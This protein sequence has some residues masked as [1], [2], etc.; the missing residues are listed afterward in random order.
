MKKLLILPIA[1]GFIAFA[2]VAPAAAGCLTGALVGGV[3]GHFVHHGAVG[4]AAGCA[5]GIHK[6]HER[7][8]HMD[9]GRSSARD[10]SYGEHN[11]Y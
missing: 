10:P 3:A 7:Q 9:S 8:R 5:Y 2:S 11:Q 1:L 4:A 6:S